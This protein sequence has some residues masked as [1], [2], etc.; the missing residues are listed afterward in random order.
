MKCSECAQAMMCAKYT[1]S[2]VEDAACEM[3]Y[4]VRTLRARAAE[5]EEANG[6]L[7]DLNGT[8]VQA[9]DLACASCP[10]DEPCPDT[11]CPLHYV[12]ERRKSLRESRP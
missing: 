3:A 2:P 9:I 1:G 10:F 5:L 12:V 6:R 7:V 11:C 4:E 8:T